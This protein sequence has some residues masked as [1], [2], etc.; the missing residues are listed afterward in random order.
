[1]WRIFTELRQLIDHHM[2]LRPS[3]FGLAHYA[4]S[5][6][7]GSTQNGNVCCNDEISTRLFHGSGS[8][9]QNVTSGTTSHSSL[10]LVDCISELLL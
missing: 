9:D 5:F 1:M 2:E 10:I 8:E 6:H 4:L 3:N 7:D